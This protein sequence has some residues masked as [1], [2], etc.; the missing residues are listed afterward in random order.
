MRL[1]AIVSLILLTSVETSMAQNAYV[2][3][4]QQAFMAPI[5]TELAE[6]VWHM[7]ER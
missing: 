3:L 5:A 4:G 7:L 6:V 1:S 2:R